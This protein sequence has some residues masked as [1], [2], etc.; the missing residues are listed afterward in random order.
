MTAGDRGVVRAIRVGDRSVDVVAS[1]S[2]WSLAA[3]PSGLTLSLRDR[4][5][6]AEALADALTDDEREHLREYLGGAK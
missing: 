5:G 4:V 1:G 3:D 2:A 6:L